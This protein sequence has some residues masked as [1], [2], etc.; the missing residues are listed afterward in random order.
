MARSTTSSACGRRFRVL[1]VGNGVAKECFA[2]A[3]DTSISGRRVARE[4][5]VLLERRAKPGLIVSD[6][7]AEFISNAMLA[8]S[9][10][11][12]RP[13]PFIAPGKPMQNGI[14]EAFNRL[15]MDEL[16]NE[17]L[18]LAWSRPLGHGALDGRPQPHPLALRPGRP[19]PGHLR[20]PSL[21]NAQ[22]TPRARSGTCRSPIAPNAR[23]RQSQ[24]GTPAWPG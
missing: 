7:G 21:R 24:P 11:A 9:E 12:K 3:V 8:W 23:A 2:A 10:K 13:W 15:T 14:C 19:S 4:L 5:T 18:F 17:T 20:R 16:L 6:R 1:N 22:S